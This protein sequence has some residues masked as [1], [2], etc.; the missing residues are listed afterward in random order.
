MIGR[1]S[2]LLVVCKQVYWQLLQYTLDRVR[3][4]SPTHSTSHRCTHLFGI[5]REVVER[6]A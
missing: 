5:G 2:V 4:L 3:S 6:E 1:C